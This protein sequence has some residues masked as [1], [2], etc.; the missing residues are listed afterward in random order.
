MATLSKFIDD[1]KGWVK[2][3]RHLNSGTIR[4][5][6]TA[7][8][9]KSHIQNFAIPESP[10]I[11][12]VENGHGSVI[13]EYSA[14]EVTSTDKNGIKTVTRPTADNLNPALI[15][16]AL[17]DIPIG[18]NGKAVTAFDAD[19]LFTY[20]SVPAVGGAIGTQTDSFIMKKDNTGFIY[21]GTYNAANLIGY[22][23][24]SASAGGDTYKGMHK[25]IVN[26]AAPTNKLIVLGE[27]LAG[28]YGDI[29]PYKNII[30]IGLYNVPVPTY[31]FPTA[32]TASGWVYI[33]IA[34]TGG[35]Y[36]PTYKF[37]T[38]EP[39]V[40]SSVLREI[41]AYVE[42]DGTSSSIKNIYQILNN[43]LHFTGRFY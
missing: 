33:E 19:A 20:D 24:P 8:G 35:S 2:R 26:P 42:W 40:S 16:F 5:E 41:I 38:S 29:R 27:D 12:V 39:T 10:H 43:Q 21:Q 28:T 36:I 4:V 34:Y 9:I 14:L 18:K 25:V 7:N 15:V 37:L 11:L 32:I 22:V 1:L 23:R 31:L 30:Y 6:R 13:S 3:N 17:E